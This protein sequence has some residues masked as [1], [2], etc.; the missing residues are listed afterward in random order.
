MAY[1]KLSSG[2]KSVIP[3]KP[4]HNWSPEQIIRRLFTD[5]LSFKTVYCWL[6][7]GLLE[8][9]LADLRKARGNR[10]RKHRVALIS[11][12]QFQNALKM[13][14]NEPHLGIGSWTPL[15]PDVERKKGVR[16]LLSNVKLVCIMPLW[17]LVDQPLQWN[18]PFEHFMPTFS[19][20]ILEIYV[21]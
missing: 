1:I 13:Y 18:K 12:Y 7:A 3:E 5:Y 6:Y 16:Q 17:C 15:C 4:N 19:G 10:Q 11:V 21:W 20:S 8:L 14:I 9:P 2:L